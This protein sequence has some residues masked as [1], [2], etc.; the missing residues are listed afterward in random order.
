MQLMAIAGRAGCEYNV[1][2][3]NIAENQPVRTPSGI[4]CFAWI[5]VSRHCRLNGLFGELQL[6]CTEV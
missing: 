5:L 3:K 6:S 1:F 2:K 4:K